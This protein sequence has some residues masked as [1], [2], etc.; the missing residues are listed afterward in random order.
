MRRLAVAG[1]DE[2]EECVSG[3]F[4]ERV[5]AVRQWVIFVLV[6]KI[7]DDSISTIACPARHGR[8]NNMNFIRNVRYEPGLTRAF[9]AKSGAGPELDQLLPSNPQGIPHH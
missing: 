9:W 2:A 8:E 6:Q 3:E 1:P 4:T 7:V 5:G